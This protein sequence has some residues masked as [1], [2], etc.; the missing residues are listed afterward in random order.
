MGYIYG[1]IG[2]VYRQMGKYNEALEQYLLA[3][4]HSDQQ[5][6]SGRILEIYAH[7]GFVHTMLGKYNLAKAAFL[8]VG[9]PYNPPGSAILRKT[10]FKAYIN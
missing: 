4:E 6:R 10:Y 1:L 8:E 5:I 7:I 9:N 2:N 3:I